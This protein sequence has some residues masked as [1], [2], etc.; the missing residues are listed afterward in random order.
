MWLVTRI[1]FPQFFYD[2]CWNINHWLTFQEFIIEEPLN[3]KI[4]PHPNDPQ[5]FRAHHPKTNKIIGG[6]IWT[7]DVN[8]G[9]PAI[10]KV[11]V[12]PAY[13]KRG[14]A[15][16]LYKHIENHIG[17]QLHPAHSLSDDG[18]EFWKHYR[19][20]AVKDDLRH[21]KDKLLGKS[22]T[23]ERHGKGTIDGVSSRTATIKKPDGS[24]YYVNRDALTKSGHI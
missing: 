17:Q 23:H 7:H 12:D 2:R 10:H 8:H 9:K 19:P 5:F 1:S 15:T 4:T 3:I 18:F 14:V 21:H 22:Y 6:A 16:Q 20:E 24:E 11:H 13:R